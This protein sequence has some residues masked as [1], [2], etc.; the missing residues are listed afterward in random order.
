MSAWRRRCAPASSA[1]AAALPRA[2]PWPA[3]AAGVFAYQNRLDDLVSGTLE[4]AVQLDPQLL[5]SVREDAATPLAGRMAAALRIGGQRQAGPFARQLRERYADT[6][7]GQQALL[8]YAGKTQELLSLSRGQ[9][10]PPGGAGADHRLDPNG[11]RIRRSW[12]DFP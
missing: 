5:S 8:L 2:T 12:R 6:R 1:C 4:Q 11:G 3:F 10:A 7:V 9:A